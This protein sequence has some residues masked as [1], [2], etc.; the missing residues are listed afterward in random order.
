[1]ISGGSLPIPVPSRFEPDGVEPRRHRPARVRP[2]EV[3]DV[4]GLLGL[5]LEPLGRPVED[6]RV[7]FRHPLGARGDDPL[8]V[9][10]D[11]DAVEEAP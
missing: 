3:P 1:M 11:P 10:E 9:P 7:R 6:R 4:Q 8:E 5:D 2:R